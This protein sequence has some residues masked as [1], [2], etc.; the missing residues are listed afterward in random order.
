MPVQYTRMSIPEKNSKSILLRIDIITIIKS[1][2]NYSLVRCNYLCFL[3]SGNGVV[4]HLPGLFEEIAKTEAKGIANVS[5]RLVIS[6]RAHL[7]KSLYLDEHAI[8]R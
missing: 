5:Q 6:T 2:C 3:F 4:I 1:C 7:G 8:G